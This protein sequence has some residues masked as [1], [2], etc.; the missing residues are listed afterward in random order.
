MFEVYTNML[1]YEMLSTRLVKVTINSIVIQEKIYFQQKQNLTKN[2]I[3][4][5]QNLPSSI[6]TNLK[7][8]KFCNI[9]TIKDN[10]YKYLSSRL[11]QARIHKHVFFSISHQQSCINFRKTP[12]IHHIVLITSPLTPS[13]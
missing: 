4:L 10:S 1:Y 13:K 2:F 9:N 6:G 7:T 8:S 3:L 11:E 5:H 12:P